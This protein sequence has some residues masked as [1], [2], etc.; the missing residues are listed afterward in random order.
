[1]YRLKITIAAHPSETM[2]ERERAAIA[3]AQARM[4]ALGKPTTGG[5]IVARESYTQDDLDM[6]ELTIDMEPRE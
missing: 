2:E 5:T 4:Q 6:V 3:T 1:M